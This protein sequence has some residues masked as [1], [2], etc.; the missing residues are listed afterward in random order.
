MVLYSDWLPAWSVEVC[1]RFYS[2][3]RIQFCILHFMFYSSSSES[4]T[5]MRRGSARARGTGSWPSGSMEDER[6]G[7]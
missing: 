3:N 2:T 4:M 5:R 6:A 1:A 7:E